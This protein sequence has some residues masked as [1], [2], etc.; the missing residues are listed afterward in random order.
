[1]G[2]LRSWE[3]VSWEMMVSYDAALKKASEQARKVVWVN[4]LG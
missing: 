2:I 4:T 1:M 3:I